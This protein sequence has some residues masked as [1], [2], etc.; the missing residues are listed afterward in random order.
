[1]DTKLS[2]DALTLILLSCRNYSPLLT[3][4]VNMLFSIFTLSVACL[5]FSCTINQSTFYISSFKSY[6]GLAGNLLVALALAF[7][8]FNI[9]CVSRYL[10]FY[11]NRQLLGELDR[12]WSSVTWL[13]YK[14]VLISAKTIRQNKFFHDFLVLRLY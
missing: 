4:N 3:T 6:L 1:L 8:N 13:N 2:A 11:D 12:I 5:H 9:D 7:C 10:I 14:T